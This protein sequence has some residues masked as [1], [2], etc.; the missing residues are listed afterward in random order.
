MSNREEILA[1]FQACTGIEDVGEAF[2]YLE[3]ANWNLSD[4]VYRVLPHGSQEL[5]SVPSLDDSIQVIETNI[6]D[7]VN[8]PT[9]AQQAH[10]TQ[11]VTMSTD[12]LTSRSRSRILD[13]HIFYHDQSKTLKVPEN[14]TVGT[15]K[16][17]IHSELGVPVCKQELSGWK[18]RPPRDAVSLE[19]LNLPTENILYLSANQEDQASSSDDRSVV[20]MTQ[21]YKLSI[22]D[23]T[24]HQL[25][26][27]NF[28]GTKSLLEVK[29][30]ISDLTA[31]PVRHQF[32]SGWPTPTT[33][34]TLLGTAGLNTPVHNLTVSER[35]KDLSK[36]GAAT[37]AR[38]SSESVSDDESTADEFEDA[39]DVVMDDLFPDPIRGITPPRSRPLMPEGIE[40]EAM[41]AIHFSEGFSGRYGHC[42]PMFFQGSLDDAMKEAVLQPARDRKLLAV[43]LHHDGSVSSNV[44]CTQVLCS[45]S[46]VSFLS[47]NFIIWG[48]DM[49][50]NSNR[51]QLLDMIARHFDSLAS[52]TL[53]GMDPDKLPLL[54]IVTRNR[55]TTEILTVIQGSLNVD[56]LM[57]QLLHAVELFSEQQRIEIT[58]EDERQAREEVKREQDEAYQLSLEADRAKEEIRRQGEAIKQRQEE[59]QRIKE[60]Q[61]LRIQEF[62]LQQKEERRLEVQRRLPPEPSLD[63]TDP[64]TTIR[65]RLPGGK[66]STRRFLADNQLQVLLDFL[67]VEGYPTEEFKVLS[68]WPRQDLTVV[69]SSRSLR[70][71]NL[72]PQETLIIEER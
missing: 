2:L 10:P 37:E 15:L 21:T 60:E 28:P 50:F 4:A 24:H 6:R 70:Q 7:G 58:E 31:I 44:F 13:F 34:D 46:V 17:L 35:V 55:A 59:E 26:V 14:Q 47:A 69:D 49:T 41:A 67:L 40:D 11:L 63:Q 61:A 25:H 66:I 30:D 57:T 52:R 39:S 16:M 19:S 45:E 22:F 48:W 71:L 32:W 38:V 27:V 20:R 23:E 54:L 72:V 68:S 18:G 43:Y 9:V 65:F 29:L 36:S 56:E 8:S 5:P 42:H 33:D 53:R 12:F 1:D 51:T 62:A 64:S 3:E